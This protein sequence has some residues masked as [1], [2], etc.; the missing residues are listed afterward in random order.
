MASVQEI[1]R[2]YTNEL[3]RASVDSPRL[4]AEVLLAHAMHVSRGDLLKAMILS[5]EALPSPEQLAFA[6]ELIARRRAGEPVAYITGVKEFYGREFFVTPATLIP[7]PDTEVLVEEALRFASSLSA[8]SHSEPVSFIDLGTGSGCIAVT[9]GLELPAWQ[10][11]AVDISAD[12]LVVAAHNGSNLG[13]GNIRFLLGDFTAPLFPFNSFAMVVANPPYVSECEY[14]TL[15]HEVARFEP[16]RAL[17]PEGEGE[18]GLEALFAVMDTA[19]SLLQPK[20]MLFMEMG[21][22]QGYALLEHAASL[23]E[24]KHCRI[25]Q[26]LAGLPRV[27]CAVRAQDAQ[28]VP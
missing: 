7:R 22:T 1:L 4:S 27:F 5:P 16:K 28:R 25:V 18:Q 15:S 23:P 10:G 17:V 19:S 2:D 3:A 14:K 6:D 26:D 8:A 11:I 20:G 24:W 9:L 21:C 12:A 13:A